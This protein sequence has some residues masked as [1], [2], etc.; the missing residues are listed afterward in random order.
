[1]TKLTE[2]F[3]LVEFTDSQTA[4]RR[5]IENFPE[6][7]D[8]KN[9]ELMAKTLEQVRT[10]LNSQP[11]LISSGYRNQWLNSAVKGSKNSAHLHGLAVDFTCPSFGTPLEICK[12]LEPHMA[13]L[14]IDQLI[15]EF[16]AWVH[17]GLSAGKPR[18]MAMTIDITG[19]R[20]G[21]A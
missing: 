3:Y 18:H 16:E 17:L 5:G 1:M 15:H 19:A 11:I 20:L 7:Q 12:K 6:G 13:G 2:H 14:H 21:L 10:L 9:V 4:A 8:R